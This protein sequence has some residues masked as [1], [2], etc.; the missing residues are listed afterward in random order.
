MKKTAIILFVLCLSAFSFA[1][2]I[3][4]TVTGNVNFSNSGYS[5]TEAGNDFPTL[6]ASSS[7]AYISINYTNTLDLIFGADVKWRI[8]ISKSDNFWHQNLNL[9]IKRTGNGSK[10]SWFGPSPTINHGTT[11]QTITNNPV[12]FF[13]GRYGISNIPLAFQLSGASL[14]MGANEFDTTIVFTIYDDW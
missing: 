2:N 1:Q 3:N 10:A 13:R 11:F 5:I 9:E 4:V 8:F 7:A 12:Y 14:S 6:S